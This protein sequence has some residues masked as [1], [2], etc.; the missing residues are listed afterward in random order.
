VTCLVGLEAPEEAIKNRHTDVGGSLVTQEPHAQSVLRVELVRDERAF[1]ALAAEWDHLLEDSTQRVYF[2][3]FSW[4]RSWWR[5]HAPPGARP[6]ILCCRDDQDRLVGIAPLYWHQHRMLGIP[7]A[8]ELTLIGMGIELKTSE[9]VDMIARRGAECAVSQAITAFLL[10]RPD[11]DRLSMSQVPSDSPFLEHLSRTFGEN[12]ASRPCDRAPYIDTSIKWEDYKKTL[13]RSMRRNVEYYARR[14]FKS[15]HCEF[16][17]AATRAE[18]VEGLDALVRLHQMRWEAAGQPGS[19]GANRLRNQ[20]FDAVQTEFDPGR[21]RL[22]TLR[23]DGEIQAAL[24]GLLDNGVLHYFQKG[25]NPAFNK[26]DVGTALLSLCLRDSFADPAINAFDFMGGGAGY[27]D[28]WAREHR[29]T[30]TLVIT[31]LSLRARLYSARAQLRETSATIYRR[32]APDALRTARR[33]FII[34]A[35][36]REQ[37]RMRDR[38]S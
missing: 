11:W 15:H 16:R 7:Y 1:D 20:L 37:A 36:A 35:K 4:I 38:P 27:K 21:V 9:Y 23:I 19:F 12:A 5:H 32:L 2:L 25:F 28:L 14:L 30:R 10:A 13:G 17:L 33:D 34:R 29:T 18:A 6:H 31:R 3:R 22:W 24:V 26:H 8:R